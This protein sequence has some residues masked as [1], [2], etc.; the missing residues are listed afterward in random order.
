MTSSLPLQSFPSA[1]AAATLTVGDTSEFSVSITAR[2]T[3]GFEES[4]DTWLSRWGNLASS[5]LG[6]AWTGAEV[7]DKGGV[8]PGGMETVIEIVL[9]CAPCAC[10]GKGKLKEG[11]AVGCWNIASSACLTMISC[12]L[13]GASMVTGVLGLAGNS[14]CGGASTGTEAAGN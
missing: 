12:D 5:N 10:W 1:L 2:S 6:A 7:A 13:A 3:W 8:A 14:A 9:G 4:S 11:N